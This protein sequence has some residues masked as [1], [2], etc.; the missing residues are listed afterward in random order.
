MLLTVLEEVPLTGCVRHEHFGLLGSFASC[1]VFVTNVTIIHYIRLSF[2][3][4]FI[5]SYL[6]NLNTSFSRLFTFSIGFFIVSECCGSAP[7]YAAIAQS[8]S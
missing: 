2:T 6:V 1:L 3:F 5:L 7:F 4:S 8:S